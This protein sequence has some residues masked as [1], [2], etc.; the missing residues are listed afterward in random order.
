MNT[1]T[2]QDVLI[3][4]A[5]AT[6]PGMLV[7]PTG[8][9]GVVLFAHGSGSSRLSPR[10]RA[11]AAELQRAGL[12]T[13]LFDLLTEEESLDRRRV[14][15]VELLAGRLDDARRWLEAEPGMEHVAVGYFG[16]ST[17]AAAALIA[18][19]D[20][21][22]AV[23][24]VVSRGGRPDLAGEALKRVAAPTLLIVGGADI[25]VVELNESAYRQLG[26]VKHLAIVPGAT[27]LFDE[28]GALETVARLAGD[29]FSRYLA[30]PTNA[31]A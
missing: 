15:D 30:P 1:L 5:A 26:G 17:G 2:R 19:A 31:P 29:W 23:R 7:L 18:A 25:G 22:A 3:P 21:P 8:A 4:A 24:A 28:P 12:G 20:H 13:L 16:A 10:N 9:T 11:V 6:L 27:H 14:F